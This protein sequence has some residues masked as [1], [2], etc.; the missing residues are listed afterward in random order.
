MHKQT[1]WKQAPTTRINKFN[2]NW[3][4]INA[5]TYIH[6]LFLSH[7]VPPRTQEKVRTYCAVRA[8]HTQTDELTQMCTFP[9]LLGRLAMCWAVDRTLAAIQ[10]TAQPRIKRTPAHLAFMP[11]RKNSVWSAWQNTHTR[12]RVGIKAIYREKP[13]FVRW[14]SLNKHHEHLLGL[15]VGGKKLTLQYFV[16]RCI[17]I[18]AIFL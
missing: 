18:T 12:T 14:H 2:D 6:R 17:A 4:H 8:G 15:H 1:T 3:M 13:M 11:L 10:Q 16:G 7:L 9:S 5:V